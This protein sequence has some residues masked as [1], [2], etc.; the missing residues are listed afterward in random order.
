[1]LITFL[2]FDH[3][4][5]AGLATVGAS[6][7][8]D[9]E[10]VVKERFVADDGDRDLAKLGTDGRRRDRAAHEEVGA[11]HIPIPCHRPSF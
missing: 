11:E 6:T 3:I 7:R 1:M 9:A 8:G 10:I 4:V 5:V 2:P